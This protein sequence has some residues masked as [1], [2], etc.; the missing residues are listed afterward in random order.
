MWTHLS[1]EQLMD[2]LEGHA[3]PRTAA[4]AAECA[5][6]RALVDHAREGLADAPKAVVP[7]PS[8]LYFTAFRR[9]LERRIA[10][11]TVPIWRWT[12]GP[13]L[14]AGVVLVAALGILERPARHVRVEAPELRLAAWTP[15][16]PTEQDEGL[17][18]IQALGPSADDLVPAS[19][20]AS[21]SDCVEG[22]SEDESHALLERMKTDMTGGRL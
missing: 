11:D 12:L 19:G 7:E 9:Q 13:A 4:H 16:P 18:L 20:C 17:A 1:A 6:C 14:A 22:L 10:A 21:V 2:A 15:L 3:D 5:R 8:P